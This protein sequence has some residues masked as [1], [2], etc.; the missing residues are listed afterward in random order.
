MNKFTNLH[1]HSMYSLLDGMSKPKDMIKKAIENEYSALCISDHGVI[2]NAPEIYSDC[3]KNKI[4]YIY[5]CELYI[6]EDRF[7][8]D[9]NNRY[10]HLLALAYNEEG[11]INLNK[12][13]SD[14]YKNGFYYK[15]R[16]DF[17]FLSAHSEGLIVS[18]ACMAGEVS[19]FLMGDDEDSAIKAVN[20]YKSVF[21]ENYYLE[22][23]A[24]K[25]KKQL[26]LNRKIIELSNK[27]N[28]PYIITCD[29]H[30]TN[31]EDKEIHSFFVKNAKD[32]D[33]GSGFY[34]DCYMMN[35]EEMYSVCS[36]NMSNDE[37]YEACNNIE[38]IVNKC[39]YV[40]IPLGKGVIPTPNIPKI[41]NNE[42]DYI[43]FL[44]YKEFCDKG[45]DKYDNSNE[46]IDRIELELDLLKKSGYDKYFLNVK[47]QLEGAKR[48]GAG[49][50]SAG[51]SIV[52][53]LLGLTKL[54]PIKYNFMLERFIDTYEINEYYEGRITDLGQSDID[55]D[56]SPKERDECVK[57]LT[58]RYGEDLVCG[59]GAVGYS[60]A[61]SSIKDIARILGIDPQ[62]ANEIT[63]NIESKE[64]TEDVIENEI[65]IEYKKMYPELFNLSSKLMGI[66]RS[67]SMHPSG[68]IVSDRDISYYAPTMVQDNQTVIMCDMNNCDMLRLLKSDLLGLSTLDIIYD[69]LDMIGK[70][71]NYID[72][73]LINLRDKNVYKML[74]EGKTDAV[75]QFSG[76][77]MTN[78][79]KK[80]KPK[81]LKDLVAATSLHRP[82][83]YEVID[84]YID[85]MHGEEDSTPIHEDLIEI[86]GDTHQ[87][88]IYQENVQEIA[89]KL[90]GISDVTKFRKK[91]SKKD[92]D[93]LKKFYHQY[94]SGLKV[95][96]WS[97][98]KIKEL[99]D[100]MIKSSKYLFNRIHGYEYTILSYQTAFL[101]YYHP[102][103]FWTAVLN[104]YEGKSEKVI[105]SLSSMINDGIKVSVPNYKNISDRCF[106]GGDSIFIGTNII[107]GL[108]AR[109][110]HEAEWMKSI[111]ITK[112]NFV[113]LLI[114]N[115]ENAETKI[116]KTTMTILSKVGFFDSVAKREWLID[117]IDQ[118]NNG[119]GLK[120]SAKLT[121][122]TK[123]A[124][125]NSLREYAKSSS[126]EQ[127]RIRDILGWET[128]YFG[129]PLSKFAGM[130]SDYA[131]IMSIEKSKYASRDGG[132]SYIFMTYGIADGKVRKLMYNKNTTVFEG[133]IIQL[134]KI[135]EKSAA[136]KPYKT[137][138]L[139]EYKKLT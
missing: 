65:P 125:L 124:R 109:V 40:E 20:R 53:W 7:E 84:N 3:I 22:V 79:L 94:E 92:E 107:K 45:I 26:D 48:I 56:L 113:D 34:D 86:L 67:Y 28:V 15:P 50:G 12:I 83:C 55:T 112:D 30:Y 35:Y 85:R 78:V 90:C 5:S 96:N 120:Y 1:Q 49:R 114:Y 4:P 135:V 18:S 82:G 37:I 115:E 29:S 116:G 111:N 36:I 72:P 51:A 100:Y 88:I 76:D 134:K 91:M 87:L 44:V 60:W 9:N 24:H 97:E 99:W 81:E 105:S 127:A 110:A 39:K 2:Y 101:K 75:F 118:F 95:R 68:K 74:S 54:D 132:A 106:V 31:I 139:Y 38:N 138:V 104:S 64:L 41:F 27:T 73:N 58:V 11:R 42:Q 136:G 6:C 47:D 57:N 98:D 70:D 32:D 129:V 8:K 108:S 52:C 14:A 117:I 10:Y 103:Q 43:R 122:K 137:P 130:P 33:D 133:G 25:N 66:T 126:P 102:L 131:Y 119:K 61:R 69:V 17:K 93:G 21:G 123:A 23:Q 80:M 13:I 77:S 71:Y 63:K 19:K 89:S 121:D 128:D 46:Y 16:T 62:I 59:I